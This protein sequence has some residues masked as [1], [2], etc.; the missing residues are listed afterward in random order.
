VTGTRVITASD[1]TDLRAWLDQYE[2]SA[3]GQGRRARV[4]R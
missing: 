4:Y 2:Q 3:W 1:L